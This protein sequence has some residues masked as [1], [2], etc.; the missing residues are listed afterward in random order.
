M[1]TEALRDA[2]LA[3]DVDRDFSICGTLL[4]GGQRRSGG[5]P[6]L[7]RDGKRWVFG[8][9]E[10]GNYTPRQYFDTEDEACRYVYEYL[11]R[12]RPGLGPRIRTAAERA[13]DDERARLVL[14]EIDRRRQSR[15]GR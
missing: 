13:A 12:P 11:T 9:Y 2:L 6:Y 4:P 8:T 14:E 15:R 5:E 7:D 1:N 10:R 3:A